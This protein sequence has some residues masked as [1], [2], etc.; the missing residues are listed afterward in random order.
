L[1]ICEYNFLD[2]DPDSPGYSMSEV[3][4]YA[5]IPAKWHS[6]MPN[7]RLSLRKNLVSG[8]YEMFRA[9]HRGTTVAQIKLVHEEREETGLMITHTPSGIEEVAFKSKDLQ[10]I[11]DWGNREWNLWH[12]AP[13]YKR[14][15]DRPCLH[16]GKYQETAMFCPVVKGLVDPED[17][18]SWR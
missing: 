17:P 8:E 2:E 13:D 16:T 10:E 6:A 12:Q 11:L 14:E 15:P 5:W 4:Y 1:R 7:H 9:Y 3:D 18:K